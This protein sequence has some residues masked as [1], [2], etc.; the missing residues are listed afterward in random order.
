MALCLLLQATSRTRNRNRKTH[1]RTDLSNVL[2]PSLSRSG[3]G[4]LTEWRSGAGISAA[5]ICTITEA[6]LG[7]EGDHV[8]KANEPWPKSKPVTRANKHEG[9]K[10]RRSGLVS[11]AEGRPVTRRHCSLFRIEALSAGESMVDG[12]WPMVDEARGSQGREARQWRR[13]RSEGSRRDQ[14]RNRAA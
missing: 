8:R 4:Q 2:V 5:C 6:E 1:R 3:E 7:S 13:R 11:R 10:K 9:G 12:R 14:L